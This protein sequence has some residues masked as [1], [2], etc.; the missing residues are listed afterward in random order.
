MKIKK[1]L[2][3]KLYRWMTEGSKN[4]G[5]ED[6]TSLTQKVLTLRIKV[7][8]ATKIRGAKE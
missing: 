5:R 4:I 1:L 6:I 3:L 7:K 2:S 8:E